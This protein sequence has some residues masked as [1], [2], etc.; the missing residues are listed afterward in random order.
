MWWLSLSIFLASSVILKICSIDGVKSVS[1]L[2]IMNKLQ[3]S[4]SFPYLVHMTNLQV[5][6]IIIELGMLVEEI[7]GLNI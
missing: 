2:G 1:S 4:W 5:L 7:C 6:K 3:E